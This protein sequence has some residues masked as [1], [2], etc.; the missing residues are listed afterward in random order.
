MSQSKK[1][2]VKEAGI[3]LVIGYSINWSC[4]MLLLPVLWDKGH[5]AR[6]AHLIGIAFTIVSFI[7]QYIIRRYM[8]KGDA[9]A[10]S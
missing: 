4:N 5:P 1:R 7:R 10:E 3:N 6:S 9:H 2:S 8:T